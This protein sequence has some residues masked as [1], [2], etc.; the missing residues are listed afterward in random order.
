MIDQTRKELLI[1]KNK[2]KRIVDG[3]LKQLSIILQRILSKTELLSL[4]ETDEILRLVGETEKNS[5]IEDI[6]PESKISELKDR[7]SKLSK[8]MQDEDVY[9]FSYHYSDKCGILK[10][11]LRDVLPRLVELALYDGDDVYIVNVRA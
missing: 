2:G 1:R 10:T 8:E 6:K 11:S 4:E 3:F 9:F 5:L 7:L